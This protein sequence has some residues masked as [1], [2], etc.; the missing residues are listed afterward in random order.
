MGNRFVRLRSIHTSSNRLLEAA[1]QAI[2]SSLKKG[3]IRRGESHEEKRDA[4]RTT[5]FLPERDCRCDVLFPRVE[6]GTTS[7]KWLR[8]W[9][10]PAKYFRSSNGT[11]PQNEQSL[12]LCTRSSHASLPRDENGEVYHTLLVDT[13]PTR[14]HYTFDVIVTP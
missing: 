3:G 11:T 7:I 6:N 1:I 13:A 2:T 12:L 10:Q 8:D 5:S 9:L 14:E 4:P